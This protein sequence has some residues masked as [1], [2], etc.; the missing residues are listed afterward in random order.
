MQLTNIFNSKDGLSLQIQANE[1]IQTNKESQKFGLTLTPQGALELL[2]ERTQVLK[3]VGRIEFDH[4]LTQKIIY[5]F[6]DSAFIQQEDYVATLVDLQ[7]VFYV[8]KNETED[9]I[10]DDELLVLLKDF[11]E[12]HCD[13]DIEYLKGKY[14]DELIRTT[15]RFNQ[16][17]DFQSEAGDE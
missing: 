4:S 7:E 16:I 1:L 9:S 12:K 15:R 11:Y 6:C 8:M 3:N 2:T 5:T 17:H 13:G 14:L 10:T